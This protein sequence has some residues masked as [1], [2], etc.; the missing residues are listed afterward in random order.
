MKP[1]AHRP[2][3]GGF[4]LIEVM[5]VVTITGLILVMLNQGLRLGVNG[6]AAFDR[7]VQTQHD[8]I[9][10]EQ[11]LRR[12]LEHADP[13]IYP[14][15]PLIAGTA[16][17]MIFT[18][19]LPDPATGATQRA[20]V[21]LGLAGNQFSLWWTP[22]GRGVAFGPNAPP[23]HRVLLSKIGRLDIAY[24]ARTASSKWLQSWTAK[25]LPGLVRMS[26]F[27]MGGHPVWPPIIVRMVTEPAEE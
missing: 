13:G 19:D 15:P 14:N 11:A 6:T 7:N 4:T 12:M 22:H 1:V 18:T 25:V 20:D 9:P 3:A 21:R 5:I 16:H 17:S 24:A 26:L 8:L 2:A 23:E 27:D 10:V